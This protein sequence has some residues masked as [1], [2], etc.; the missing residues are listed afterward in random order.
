MATGFA[1]RNVDVNLA[2]ADRATNSSNEFNRLFA[3]GSV[4][5]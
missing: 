1:F 4:S 2:P 5:K 3:T